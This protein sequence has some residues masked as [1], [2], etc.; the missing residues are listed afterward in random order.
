MRR[1]AGGNDVHTMGFSWRGALE[2]RSRLGKRVGLWGNVNGMGLGVSAFGR[3]APRKASSKEPP[4]RMN[5]CLGAEDEIAAMW[6]LSGEEA[7]RVA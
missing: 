1:R 7:G 3:E 2:R 4:G 6:W 5:E